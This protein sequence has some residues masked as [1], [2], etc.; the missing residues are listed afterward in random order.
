ML[1]TLISVFSRVHNNT[2][3]VLVW[4]S[5][6]KV[7]QAIYM[8]APCTALPA[9]RVDFQEKKILIVTCTIQCHTET[10]ELQYKYR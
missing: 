5:N 8:E 1:D 7:I 10:R 4:L 9:T 2:L 3:T 6:A